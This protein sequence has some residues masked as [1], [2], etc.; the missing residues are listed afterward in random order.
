MGDI[1]IYG[2]KNCDTMKKAFRFLDEAGATYQFHDYKK[3]GVDEAVL[4]RTIDQHGWENVI[5]RRGTTW[6]KLPEE[7]QNAMDVDLAVKT[8]MENSSIVKRPLLV[9]GDDILLGFDTA[10]YAGVVGV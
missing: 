8:A 7:V 6:R 10:V 2:I 4:R 1:T 3:Q 9:S 5:N